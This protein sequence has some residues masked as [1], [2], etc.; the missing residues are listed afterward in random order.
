[1]ITPYQI[2]MTIQYVAIALLSGELLYACSQKPSEA[3]KH[4]SI[5]AIASIVM[6]GGYIIEI[7]SRTL[8][9]AMLGTA[10]SY[11][12]KPFIMVSSLLLLSS[13]FRIKIPDWIVK[14]SCIFSTA[15]CILI[16]TN[17]SHHLYYATTSYIIDG[18]YSP[19]HI[20]RGPLYYLYILATV[21]FF[22][23]CLYVI[24]KGRKNVSKKQRKL[25][26]LFS[27]L[28]I[29]SGL[30]GYAAFLFVDTNGY[31]STMLGVLGGAICLFFIFAKCHIFDTLSLV[32]DFAL[33]ESPTGL[34]VL[35]D[36]N[37]IMYQNQLMTDIFGK[38]LDVNE[39][40]SLPEE[41]TTRTIGEKTYNIMVKRLI[42]SGEEMGKAIEVT[43]ITDY[44]NYQERLEQAVVERTEKLESMQRE[45]IGSVANIVEARS[46]E[47]GEH[48]ARTSAYTQMIAD[49]LREMGLYQDLL[50]DEYIT[51]LVSAAPLHDIGKVS[52][53]D[54]ILLKPGKLTMDEFEIMKT[55][56]DIGGRIIE[57]TLKGLESE[58]YV[59]MAY[60]IAKYHHERWDGKGYSQKISGT[61]IPLCARIVALADCYDAITSK[62]VYK[63]AVESEEAMKII[64]EESGSHFDPDVVAAFVRA[65]EKRKSN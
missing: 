9:E 5:L 39:F 19:L 8:R 13:Y 21:A 50:T 52:V 48:I 54:A 33:E 38:D 23:G 32:K 36:D 29:C 44:H 12:G 20:T 24:I 59:Q 25:L 56:V 35:N 34:L 40:L 31:D 45:I 26:V 60:D 27:V 63:E 6:F 62:R 1:M 46:L 18:K 16:F 41:H 3:Q 57:T 28:M 2:I 58:E 49:S 7:Q 14:A 15:F 30:L 65:M 43:D 47:T 61:D 42:E 17:D 22:L 4:V 10:I 51:L 11:I 53:P 37:Q 55:H 64:Q